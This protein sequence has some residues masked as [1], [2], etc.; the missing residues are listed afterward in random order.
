MCSYFSSI[1]HSSLCLETRGTENKRGGHARVLK[2]DITSQKTDVKE[3]YLV[4]MFL[5]LLTAAKKIGCP[6][7]WALTME[8]MVPFYR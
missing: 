2:Q 5:F 4:K 8:W 1:L 3:M 7:V 6:G